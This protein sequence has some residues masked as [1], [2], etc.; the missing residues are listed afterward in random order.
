MKMRKRFFPLLFL[1]F[2]LLSVS[3][4]AQEIDKNLKSG[5]NSIKPMEAYNSVKTMSSPEFAGRYTGATGYTKAA[6]WAAKK[7]KHWGLKPMNKE[8][9]YLQPFPA[10]Y[11]LIKKS[12]MKLFLPDQES[13]VDLEAGVDFLPLLYADNGNH[14]AELVF[15]GWGVSAP[16]LSYDDY[17]GLDV[18]GKFVVC[19]RGVPDRSNPGFRKYDEHRR[20][21][22]VAKEKGA[23]GLF[24]I[25]KEPIANPN[26]DWIAGFTPA[27]ISEKVADRILKE[28]GLTSAELKK[29]LLKYKRPLSFPLKAKAQFMVASQTFPKGIGYN[30]I[31]YI[32]G[33]DAKL[34]KECI[35]MGG[36]FDHCGRHLG[37]LFPGAND[38]ASGSAVVMELAEAFAKLKHKPKRSMVFI[39]FGGEEMGLKGSSYF[40]DHVPQQF[41]KVDAMF[42]FDMVGEGNGANCSY[43]EEPSLFIETIKNADKTVHILKRLR[44]LRGPGGGS[45]YAPFHQKGITAAA[46]SSNGPHLSYHQTGDTI[47]RINPDI[48]ADIAK[49]AFISAFKWADR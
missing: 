25:Y 17:A 45:D 49:M 33:S 2:C 47:Y 20:R 38:N 5:F 28:K 4:S 48:M 31:G 19:F 39:L 23:L 24:Y 15:V 8:N 40:V 27:K 43:S 11:T 46:F 9:G 29:D 37:L 21:M 22:R 14:T 36:H 18:S 3:V 26:G 34:K 30:I 1:L 41:E 32:P 10:P 42:N 7:F 12:E 44:A 35:V 6:N 16:E 13:A